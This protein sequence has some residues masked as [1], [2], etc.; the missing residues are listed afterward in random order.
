MAISIFNVRKGARYSDDSSERF[1]ERTLPEIE[2]VAFLDGLIGTCTGMAGWKISLRDSWSWSSGMSAG[3]ML[4]EVVRS[5]AR[6]PIL[7]V[8]LVNTQCELVRVTILYTAHEMSR[9]KNSP[10]RIFV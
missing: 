1:R 8:C 3:C 9:E 10:R 2:S 7:V 5:D 6:V 4:R